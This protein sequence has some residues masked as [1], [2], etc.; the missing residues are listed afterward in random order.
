MGHKKKRLP[1]SRSK[2]WTLARLVKI[3]TQFNEILHKIE[4]F[5]AKSKKTDD[6]TRSINLNILIQLLLTS[7]CAFRASVHGIGM[8]WGLLQPKGCRK[9]IFLLRA[10]NETTSARFIYFPNGDNRTCS[11][12][13]L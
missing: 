1:T 5:R 11:Q 12:P 13:I 3:R 2:Q 9:E 10:S 8:V 4:C 7:F 6:T